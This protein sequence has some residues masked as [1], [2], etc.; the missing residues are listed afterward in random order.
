MG[1]CALLMRPSASV[2][3]RHP[4]Q[5]SSHEKNEDYAY[6]L[7]LLSVHTYRALY[8]LTV[9]ILR[10]EHKYLHRGGVH[11]IACSV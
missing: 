1:L 9:K 5:F 6:G 8:H 4:Q 11:T 2:I 3:A 10:Q 7:L